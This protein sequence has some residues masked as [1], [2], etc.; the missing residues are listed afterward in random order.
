M[1]K[2]NGDATLLS[3]GHTLPNPIGVWT[4]TAIG[5]TTYYRDSRKYSRKN[6]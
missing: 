6:W 2:Q 5:F 1:V 3:V 4:F